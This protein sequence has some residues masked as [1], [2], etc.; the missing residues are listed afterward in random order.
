MLLPMRSRFLPNSTTFKL[1]SIA[2]TMMV[3]VAFAAFSVAQNSS[4]GDVLAPGSKNLIQPADLA[5]A[6]QSNNKPMVLYVGPAMFYQHAHVAGAE[7]VGQAGRADGLAK[8]HARA[9]SLPHEQPIV[10]YCGCC[11]WEHCPNIRPAF[12]ELEKMGFTNVRVLYLPTSFGVD[13]AEKGYPIAKG[14]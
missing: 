7:F 6:L 9:A 11:P 2:S 5:K 10:I 8:L 13:W 14:E 1:L 12:R 4:Q 3:M